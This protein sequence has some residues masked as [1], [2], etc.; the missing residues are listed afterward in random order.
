MIRIYF[1]DII[2]LVVIVLLFI[3]KLY[4]VNGFI[5][6]SIALVLGYYFSKR[7]YEEKMEG[8]NGR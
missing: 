5:D 2:A 7:V 3:C 6:A 4:G 8:K 1:R